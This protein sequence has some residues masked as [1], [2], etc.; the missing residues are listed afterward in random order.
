M[1]GGGQPKG[2]LK[3]GTTAQVSITAKTVANALVVPAAAILTGEGGTT[4][5]MV[6]KADSRAYSQDVKTGIQQ[7]PMIQ[8][9]SGLAA[10]EQVI[11]S[12]QYGL[13][14]KT[15]VKVT[16][17]SASPGKKAEA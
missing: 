9:L 3:P 13:P 14:D 4:S 2:E 15:K 17:A 6:V 8:V 12:G 7:G 5:V 11:V 1:G 10:G 16:P